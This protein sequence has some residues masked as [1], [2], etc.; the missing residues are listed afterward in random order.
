MI[1]NLKH[2]PINVLLP[3]NSIA[4]FD[5]EQKLRPFN[6][7]II[8]ALSQLGLFLMKNGRQDP[9]IVAAGYW[10]R[11][12]QLL[13]IKSQYINQRKFAKGI[14][15]HIAPG[16]VDSL[17]FY[18]LV[19]SVLCGNQTLLRI[20]NQI[21]DETQFFIR[22]LNAFFAEYSEFSAVQALMRIVQYKHAS[23]E[24]QQITQ[25]LSLFADVRVIWGGDNTIKE[26]SKV[27]LKVSACDIAF[28]DRYSVAVIQL[29]NEQAVEQAVNNLLTDIKPFYQQAC[30]SPK[31]I[32]WLE[33]AQR[34]QE[35]FWL[36]LASK[37]T[38]QVTMNPTDLISRMVYL[39]RLP[40]LFA[41]AQH[42]QQGQLSVIHYEM[43]RQVN[44]TSLP[45]EI[46][47]PHCGLWVLLSTQIKCLTDM[48]LFEHCQT[49]TVTGV[50]EDIIQ[51]WQQSVKLTKS[52]TAKR[53]VPSGQALT[54][55]HIWDGIDFIDAL[56]K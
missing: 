24:G 9:S 11:K 40:L 55:S 45:L 12:K 37:L 35:Q 6:D 21:S 15:F 46:I 4:L 5:D 53:I 16:N 32:Y 18:S 42:D 10:L 34:L 25:Q 39:Q 49:I 7:E 20:S 19:V 36:L 41:K 28:P 22:L 13:D 38:K 33:T 48:K 31:V 3:E 1:L 51:H 30:S 8:S 50:D 17:F 23:L 29:N 47:K 14:A 54:F 2:L 56:T 44:V 52:H 43:L 26:I 27:P